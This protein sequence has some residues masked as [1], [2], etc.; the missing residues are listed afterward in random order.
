MVASTFG[1]IRARPLSWLIC[2][3]WLRILFK[4]YPSKQ[5]VLNDLKC[6]SWYPHLASIKPWCLIGCFFKLDKPWPTT[7]KLTMRDERAQEIYIFEYNLSYTLVHEI[8]TT[9]TTTAD[10]ANDIPLHMYYLLGTKTVLGDLNYIFNSTILLNQKI[11]SSHFPSCFKCW[12]YK[13]IPKT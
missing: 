11:E 4:L 13:L 12:K 5:S 9:S 8:S 1:T 7:R 6:S 2:P 10:D 3:F